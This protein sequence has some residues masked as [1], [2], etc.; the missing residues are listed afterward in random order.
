[1]KFTIKAYVL[2]CAYGAMPNEET[3]EILNWA[4]AT[5]Y[6]LDNPAFKIEKEDGEGGVKVQKFRV[7]S[8]EVAKEIIRAKLPANLV[9]ECSLIPK[10]SKGETQVMVHALKNNAL[11]KAG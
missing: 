8:H 9:L 4:N 10:G 2:R 11:A 3:G 6:S 5:A 1:M 7:E